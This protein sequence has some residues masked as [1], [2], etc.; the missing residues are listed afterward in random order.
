MRLDFHE[1]QPPICAFVLD[2]V[3]NLT[4]VAVARAAPAALPIK[5]FRRRINARIRFSSEVK[6]SHACCDNSVNCTLLFALM[7]MVMVV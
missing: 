4:R 3:F 1:M 2:F 6:G 7:V 5:Q